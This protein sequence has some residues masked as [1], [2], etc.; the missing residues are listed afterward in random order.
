LRVTNTVALERWGENGEYGPYRVQ[1]DG[2]PYFSDVFRDYLA[3]SKLSI[4]QFAMLYGELAKDDRTSY[5]K[6][7]IY[8]MIRNNSFPTDPGRRWILAKLL[9]IPPLLLGVQ[10]LDELLRQEE[11]TK[12]TGLAQAGVTQSVKETRSFH[13]EEYRQV[14][15]EYW[16]QYRTN[17]LYEVISDIHR[18]IR[19]LERKV[20]YGEQQVKE[21]SIPLLCGYHM[22]LSNID[23]DREHYDTAITHLN[24][25]YTL[26]KEKGLS[27]LQTTILLRRGWACKERGEKL[28]RLHNFE[29][30]QRD[31][32]CAVSDYQAALDIAKQAYPNLIGVITLSQGKIEAE[33]ARTPQSFK[34]A[35]SKIDQAG[36][37][38]GQDNDDEDIHFVH[39]DEVRYHLDRAQ[40]Y[41][42]APVR[43]VQYPRDARR[44]LREAVAATTPPYPKRRQAYN[45]VLNAQSYFIE[46]E[47]EQ[48]AKDAK[49]ALILARE[50]GSTINV[51]RIASLY[52]S[53]SSTDYPKNSVD[54][55]MLEIELTKTQYPELF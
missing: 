24:Q 46:R 11:A 28:A 53:I 35:M 2:L 1:K 41:L 6:G 25:A 50:I 5:T 29:A 7:R 36:P 47:Y 37:F 14:L 39:T 3:Q 51:E 42:V 45:L 34:N 26:A 54:M 31:F 18:R 23:T 20:L 49:D 12:K 13:L 30:A 21:Q 27:R 10:S 33:I 44:E 9:S 48:S 38:V 4:V 40:A 22:L 8:Q 43:V 32:V 16:H 55:V 52:E 15:G 17:T 19:A